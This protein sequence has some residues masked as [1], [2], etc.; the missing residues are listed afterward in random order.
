LGSVHLEHGI[1]HYQ[2]SM[3]PLVDFDTE[4]DPNDSRLVLQSTTQVMVPPSSS[5]SYF[6]SIE[7]L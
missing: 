1:R 6:M 7:N 4:T 5:A 3:M 2:A